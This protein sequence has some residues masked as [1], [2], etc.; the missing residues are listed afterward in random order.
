M[1]KLLLTGCL[2]PDRF[3]KHCLVFTADVLHDPLGAIEEPLCSTQS[4]EM[5]VLTLFDP[6]LVL[7]SEII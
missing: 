3:F 2:V 6:V 4:H 7:S 1:R 5:I